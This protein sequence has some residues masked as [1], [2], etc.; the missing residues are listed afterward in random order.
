MSDYQ[1][2]VIQLWTWDTEMWRERTRGGESEFVGVQESGLNWLKG[3]YRSHWRVTQ[4]ETEWIL[5]G[6]WMLEVSTVKVGMYSILKTCTQQTITCQKTVYRQQNQPSTVAEAN[7]CTTYE[8]FWFLRYTKICII[9]FSFH[10]EHINH[11]MLVTNF[12]RDM[13][14]YI[15]NQCH[16]GC[17][18]KSICVCDGWFV[19]M[20]EWV[21]L[22]PTGPPVRSG[23]CR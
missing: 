22:M 7:V 16:M 20:N 1:I 9:D 14:M 15:I 18:R 19:R 17:S 11:F 13:K 4:M 3:K 10:I 2:C 8:Q 12:D 23:R 5:T 6:Q 21:N